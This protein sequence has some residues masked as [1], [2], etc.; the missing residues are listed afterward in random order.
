MIS[1]LARRLVRS[2]RLVLVLSV[3]ATLIAGVLGFTVFSNLG[4][5]GYDN[6]A[7]DSAQAT[8]LVDQDFGGSPDLVFLIHARG[9]DVDRPDAVSSGEA[10]TQKLRTNPSLTSVTSY[11]GTRAP[12]LRSS[13]G[14]DALILAQLTGTEQTRD[15]QAATVLDEYND[16]SDGVTSVLVGGPAGIDLGRQTTADVVLAESIAIPV[17]LILLV[18]VFGSAVAALLP[19]VVAL[20][21]IVGSF[22]ILNGLTQFTDVSIFAIN[23]VTALGLGLGV[24]YALL[25]VSRY[26]EELRAGAT[27]REGVVNTLMTAGR[28]IAFSAITVL[29]ALSAMLVFP[30]YFLKSFAYAGIAVVAVAALAALVVLPALL[31]VLGERVNSGKLPWLGKER[32]AGA[33][34]WGR[35]TQGVMRRPLVVLL[36]TLVLLGLLATPLL[37]IQSGSPDDRVLPT[38]APAHRVGDSLRSG[39]DSDASS[40]LDLVITHVSSSGDVQ[41]LAENVSRID[42]IGRVDAAAGSLEHGSAVEAAAGAQRFAAADNQ[43]MVASLTVDPTSGAAEKIVDQVRALPAPLGGEILVGGPTAAL[44]D[45]TAAITDNLWLAILIIIAVTMI[46]LFL[47]TGSVV[48]PMRAVLGNVVTLGA[49]FGVMVWMFQDGHLSSVFGFT[50]SPMNYS[51]L[52]LSAC[53]AFGL[54][55]DYEVFL[56]GRIK[57]ARDQGATSDHAVVTGVSKTGRIITSCAALLAVSFFAF[58]TG[59]VSFIQLFGLATGLAILIDA[60]IVRIVLVPAVM[61]LLGERSWYAPQVLRRIH[62]KIGISK[63]SS[64]PTRGREPVSAEA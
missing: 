12:T 9:G 35:M 33:S 56:L 51:M 15:T 63:T 37:G 1:S 62:A 59:S 45:N 34:R 54:S 36:P 40:S 48:H 23:L 47:F 18:L 8:K 11:F 58:A 4:T 30:P 19:M 64:Q 27:P 10:L 38:S 20:I 49:T 16:S 26:R 32:A 44:M 50:P 43:R 60:T 31:V 39:F 42:G 28:T 25:F 46:L 61:K 7:S 21:S 13:D 22:A 17:V 24:D 6:P 3:L 57:E 14:A 55:M 29:A 5:Q 41:T 52:V 53:V 2:A